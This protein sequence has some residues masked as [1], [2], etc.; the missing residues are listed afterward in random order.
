MCNFL[1]KNIKVSISVMRTRRGF[2]AAVLSS[3]KGLTART[4]E[5][6]TSVNFLGL[7]QVF[8]F[9]PPIFPGEYWKKIKAR[10]K[11]FQWFVDGSVI[12]HKNPATAKIFCSL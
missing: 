7:C 4:S 11:S 3:P 2:D 5:P 9:F 1:A 6:L 10:H 8:S 12:K